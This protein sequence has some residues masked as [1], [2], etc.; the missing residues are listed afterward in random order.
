MWVGLIQSAEGLDRTKTNSPPRPSPADGLLRLPAP[1][2]LLGLG[3]ALQGLDS[4]APAAERAS[5]FRDVAAHIYL[6][7]CRLCSL[8]RADRPDSQ[9]RLEARVPGEKGAPAAVLAGPQP[10]AVRACREKAAKD[11]AARRPPSQGEVSARKGRG[12]RP[13]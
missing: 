9:G 6:C 3:R 13:M 1:S 7:F 8:E 11:A 2:G 4:P 5:S 12:G 10:W